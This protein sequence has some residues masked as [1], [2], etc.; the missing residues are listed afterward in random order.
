MTV[1]TDRLWP[2]VAASI[3]IGLVLAIV[4]LPWWLAALRPSWLALIIV[5]WLLHEPRR[6]GLLTAFLGGLF[7][8]TLHGALLGQHALAL[9]LIGFVTQRFNLRIRVF[10]MSQQIATVLML[11]AL[12]EFMLYWV[13][14]VSGQPASDWRR[15]LP[16][17]S[18]AAFWPVVTIVMQKLHRPLP[19]ANRV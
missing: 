6:V 1:A 19:Q 14:G 16:V 9:V 7:L 17:L 15:W 12:Y 3:V 11:I 13:D 5:Y 2:R 10:P 8:D 4:P 18:S